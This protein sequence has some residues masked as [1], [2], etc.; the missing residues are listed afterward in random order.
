MTENAHIWYLDN[1]SMMK[2]LKPQA[3]MDLEKMTV[4]ADVAKNQAV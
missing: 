3:L 1:F 2:V 4:M